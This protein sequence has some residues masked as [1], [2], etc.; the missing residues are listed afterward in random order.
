MQQNLMIRNCNGI[1]VFEGQA[2]HF[3]CAG[4]LVKRDGAQGKTEFVWDA[5]GRLIQ[6]IT[7][8]QATVYAYDP[9]GRR[10]YKQ[11][12]ATTVR[13]VWDG[14]ALLGELRFEAKGEGKTSAAG[15]DTGPEPVCTRVREWVYYPGSFKPLAL[16]EADGL[17]GENER[18]YYY[19]NLPN[20][21]NGKVVWA[22]LYDAWGKVKKLP[23]D[24][25]EQPIRL[26]GQFYDEETGLACNRFRYYDSHIG[27][28][29]SQDPLGLA[30]GSNVYRFAP[31]VYK[32]VDPLGLKCDHINSENKSN[33]K[34]IIR[35]SF[36]DEDN[37][38]GHYSV[39][40]QC[41]NKSIHT[42]QVIT[43]WDY[44]TTTV[45]E[46]LSEIPVKEVVIDL[47]N[48]KGAMD[49]QRSVFGKEL[50]PYSQK[51]NS[52]VDHVCNVLRAGE[53]DIPNSALGQ[54]KFLK[55]LGF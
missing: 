53:V 48:P 37:P 50:G 52:C 41:E 3:D 12:D 23:V 38:F 17:A 19:C 4:N 40:T 26:Q 31:N 47:P 21:E 32:W 6:S 18:I 44:N 2:Y 1:G 29:V 35:K 9:F 28:F 33:G 10:I 54:F 46:V 11:T 43:S 39:E 25:V 24:E 45:D 30:A 15:V 51:T 34:A 16:V 14:D 42:E 7:V 22:A 13:F 20:D 8:G 36:P 49:Y 55:G 27:A 5:N